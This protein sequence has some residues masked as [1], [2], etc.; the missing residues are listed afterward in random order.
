MRT[1]TLVD[2]L[3]GAHAGAM[4]LEQSTPGAHRG[5]AH[6]KWL[7]SWLW[8]ESAWREFLYLAFP[9]ECVVC[10][11]EDHAICP[12]CSVLLRRQTRQP[13]RA[14][15]AADA[16]VGVEGESHLPV[17]AAGEYRD[18]LAATILAYKNH[19]RTELRTSLARVLALALT[20]ALELTPEHEPVILVPI[21][22]TGSGWRR[23]GYDPVALLLRSLQT[24]G[25]VPPQLFIAP[26]LGIKARP[27][28]QRQHQKGLG[29]QARRRNVRNTMCIRRN[30]LVHIRPSANHSGPALMLVDDVL[31]TGSTLREATKTLE[32][33]GFRVC[34]ATVLAATRAPEGAHEKAAFGGR[35]KN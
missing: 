4:E 22:S 23:R 14:E 32:K 15:G 30:K 8:C 7:R 12:P 1:L 5:I 13:F 31:T 34:S 24:E 3:G 17:V 33:W 26:L 18:A 25:R 2:G 9:A 19:G 16:L 29:R 20:V 35:A 28:W 6:G 11:A 27:P 21:P 10:G